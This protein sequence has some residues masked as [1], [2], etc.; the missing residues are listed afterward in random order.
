MV[1]SEM[2]YAHDAA[3]DQEPHHDPD[4][5]HD[6]LCVL[7]HFPIDCDL[8]EEFPADRKIEDG[9]N[10]DWTE[11]SDKGSLCEML[12]L[13]DVLV[14]CE[15][16]RHTADQEDQNAQ[17]NESIDR[18]D[19]VVHEGRPRT[20]GAKPHEHCQVEKHINGWLE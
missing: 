20:H 6:L 14:H 3:D 1:D 5:I 7:A 18:N 4:G 8:L 11:E 16:D 2:W 19:V 13:V 12:D 9:A 15:D 10:T 17:E